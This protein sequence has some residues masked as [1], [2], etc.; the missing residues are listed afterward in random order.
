MTNLNAASRT[1]KRAGDKKATGDQ[2]VQS[3]TVFQT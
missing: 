1:A 3:D 2:P